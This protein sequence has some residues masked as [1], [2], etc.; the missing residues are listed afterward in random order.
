VEL[1]RD[2]LA[3]L[4]VHAYQAL[5]FEDSPSGVRAAKRARVLCAA[6]PNEITRGAALED[7]PSDSE[8]TSG[9]RDL[10]SGRAQ[11]RICRDFMVLRRPRTG[12]R[13][14]S[15]PLGLG[16]D[17]ETTSLRVRDPTPGRRASLSLYGANA[18]GAQS[19]A[20]RSASG[21]KERAPPGVP[22][23]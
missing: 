15:L 2:A 17:S 6:V 7:A 9:Q 21:N 14:V 5:A 18:T 8:P 20:V 23:F 1:Y 19:C 11:R 16:A 3:V 22:S 4:E 10:A 12:P 13:V